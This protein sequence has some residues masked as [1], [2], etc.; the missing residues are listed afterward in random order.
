MLT[1]VY[2]NIHFFGK[3]VYTLQSVTTIKSIVFLSIKTLKEYKNKTTKTVEYSS[4]IIADNLP[5]QSTS[6]F[7]P[8]I[9]TDYVSGTSQ[10]NSVGPFERLI[11]NC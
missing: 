6:F 10:P 3:H 4:Q 9:A 5:V 1:S 2:W 7:S 11:K 8:S